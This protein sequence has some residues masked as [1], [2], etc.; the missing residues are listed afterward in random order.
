MAC[1]SSKK[2]QASN[3]ALDKMIAQERYQITVKA[4]QPMLTAA[5]TQISNSGLIAPGNTVNR[6]E[7]SGS[8]YFVRIEGD[9]VS[10]NLPYYGERQI[11]GGLGNAPSIVFDGVA[12]DFQITENE[13]KK[14][15]SITFNSDTTA[16][17][18]RLRLNIFPNLS[19]T[20]QVLS[21][22]RTQIRYTGVVREIDQK[23]ISK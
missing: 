21:S 11:G 10:A 7:V 18:Y 6:I 15:Y 5:M 13:V 22:H 14:S 12:T 20:I 8:G 16:E 17:S 3:G 1:N 23:Q 4:M 19:S 9:S 2:V